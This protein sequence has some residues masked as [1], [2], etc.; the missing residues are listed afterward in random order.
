MQT[1]KKIQFKKIDIHICGFARSH[2][3]K[4]KSEQ[5]LKTTNIRF[6]NNN[7]KFSF[8]SLSAIQ[9]VARME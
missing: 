2:E 1:K 5:N 9:L 4:K 6:T 8:F 7:I 3:K